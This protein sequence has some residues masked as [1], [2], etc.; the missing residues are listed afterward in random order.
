MNFEEVKK[1][2]EE[3]KEKDN[4]LKEYLQGFNAYTVEGVQKYIVDNKEATSWLDSE[5]DKHLNKGIDTFKSNNL[6][7][8]IDEK[9]KELYPTADPKDQELKKLQS[10]IENIKRESSRKELTNKALKVVTEKKLP[11]SLVEYFIGADEES[12]LKNLE[13][14]EKT[15]TSSVTSLVDEKLK[16]SSYTP[17]GDDKNK[18]NTDPFLEGLGL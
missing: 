11:V 6:Q 2:I 5:K 13:T 14:F 3:N 1:Y 4:S 7:K 8:L 10:E 12:T 18:G 17:A 15:F 16:S 9:V